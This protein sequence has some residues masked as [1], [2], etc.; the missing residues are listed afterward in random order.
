MGIMDAHLLIRENRSEGWMPEE[1][2]VFIISQAEV[3]VGR[4]LPSATAKSESFW[5]FQPEG[6][7]G[8]ARTFGDLPSP[9]SK[10][11]LPEI[12]VDGGPAI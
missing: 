12:Q 11:S 6:H 5:H 7:P 9:W 4:K 3:W 8:P 1:K 10:P 2:G